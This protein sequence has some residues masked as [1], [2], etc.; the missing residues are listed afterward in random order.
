MSE[1]LIMSFADTCNCTMTDYVLKI[2]NVMLIQQQR[3]FYLL[4]IKWIC[5]YS[6]CYIYKKTYI[7]SSTVWSALGSRVSASKL[8][9]NWQVSQAHLRALYYELWS[10]L[11]EAIS[12]PIEYRHFRYRQF[13]H[14]SAHVVGAKYMPVCQKYKYSKD[15]VILML[16]R[17]ISR[18]HFSPKCAQTLEII[19]N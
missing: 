19:L 6:V 1:V 14:Y 3:C 13:F 17:G 8:R 10:F 16:V 7:C 18:T 4:Y 5:H 2:S 15:V 12:S 11:L 9:R